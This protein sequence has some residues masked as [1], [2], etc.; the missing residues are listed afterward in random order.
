MKLFV[1]HLSDIHFEKENDYGDDNVC[2]IVNAL[3]I[4]NDIEAVLAIV[5]G[6]ITFS[7]YRRQYSTGWKFFKALRDKI[8]KKYDVGSIE[9]AV[10]PG[11]HDLNCFSGANTHEQIK[12]W[13]DNDSLDEHIEDECSKMGAFYYYA[14]VLQCFTY[15]KRLK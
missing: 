13:V 8:R 12:S 7:G 4:D 14:N 9:F 1:L 6:D 10:V 2:A 15:K 5:S 11:N 3:K